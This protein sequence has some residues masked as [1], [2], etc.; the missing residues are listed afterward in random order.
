[1]AKDKELHDITATLVHETEKAYLIDD[2]GKKVW[3]PKSEVE[4]S[5]DESTF[6]MPEWIA[7]DK[8]LI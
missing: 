8:G 3:V 6:T 5:E 1:M 2:G 4:M 7:K